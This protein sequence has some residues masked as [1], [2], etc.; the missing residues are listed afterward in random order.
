MSDSGERIFKIPVEKIE[1]G[2]TIIGLFKICIPN[3]GGR[4]HNATTIPTMGKAHGMAE[5]V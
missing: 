4:I 5:F 1:T 3:T 2:G